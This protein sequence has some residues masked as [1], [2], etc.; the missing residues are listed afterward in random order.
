MPSE[1][2]LMFMIIGILTLA[3][4]LEFPF[5]RDG[6][7]DHRVTNLVHGIAQSSSKILFSLILLEIFLRKQSEK[8]T[9]SD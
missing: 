6:L 9:M 3:H 2:F 8:I 7:F 4:E 5:S 1:G